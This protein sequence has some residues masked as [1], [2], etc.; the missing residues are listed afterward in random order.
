[1]FYEDLQEGYTFPV[2]KK[3]PITRVQLV[4][5]AGASG[6]F[7]P[8]HTVEEVGQQAGTGIIAHGMLILGMAS[9]GVTTWIPRKYV[10]KLQV[11]FRKMTLPGEEIQVSGKILEK[12]EDNRVVGEVLAMNNAGEVKVAGTFE[13]TLPSKA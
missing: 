7:N 3:D 1:M 6:D 8:L 9:Q 5:F 2:L 4:K 11:R 10:T 13:A 12:K